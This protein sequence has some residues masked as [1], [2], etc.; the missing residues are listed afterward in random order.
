MAGKLAEIAVKEDGWEC[1]V[2]GGSCGW[3]VLQVGRWLIG[4]SSKWTATEV[5]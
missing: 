4:M 3:W 1:E 5:R 2:D